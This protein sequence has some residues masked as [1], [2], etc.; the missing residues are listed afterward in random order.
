L[1]KLGRCLLPAQQGHITP[2]VR[3][4]ASLPVGPDRLLPATSLTSTTPEVAVVRRPVPHPDYDYSPKSVWSMIQASPARCPDRLALGIKRDGAWVTWTYKQYLEE[5]TTVAKAFIKLGLKPHHGVCIMGFNSPEWFISDIAAIVAGGLAT[6]IYTTNSPSAVEYVARHCRANILVVADQEQLAKVLEVREGLPELTA[7]VQYD[8]KVTEPGVLS[9]AD[10][11]QLGR[12]QAEEELQDRLRNQAVNQA[13]M[14]VYTSGT[15]GNPKGAMISQDNLTWTCEIAKQQYGWQEDQEESVTYLPLSHI[16]GNVIDIF[17]PYLAGGT[18][19]FADKD[20]LKGSLVNTLIEVRPTRFLGV[21]RVWEKIQEKL[22]EVG[23]KN[24]GLKKVVATWAKAASF[25]HHEDQMAGRPGNSWKY[26]LAKKVILTRVHA[27]LGLERAAR[28]GSLGGVYSSAAPLS[29]QTF[30]YFQ[31]LDLFVLEFLGSTETSGPMTACF[32]GTGTKQGS[33]GRGYPQFETAILAPQGEEG[34]IATRGRNCCMGYLW[35]EEKTRELIDAE[36]WLHS[37]DLGRM[38]QDGFFYI[39][40]R[41]K[42]IIITAGGENIAPVPIED[43][44]KADPGI[45]EVVS[46]AMVVGDAR[47][48]LAVILTLKSLIDENGQPLEELVPEVRVWLRKMGST[49]CT[50]REIMQEDGPGIHP[51]VQAAITE[52]LHRVNA[53]SVSKA[54]RIHKFLLLPVDFS[55]G[56]G[57]LTPTMKMRRHAIVKKYAKEVEDMYTSQYNNDGL[58]TSITV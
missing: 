10:L 12:Q 46:H 35:D 44:I 4:L 57:E 47:K 11:L 27:A 30:Q 39:T 23:S 40:G 9:W 53:L 42:E 22:L 55:I 16:A 15:T 18:V 24:T 20:A 31:A 13:C 43:N 38:D 5:I 25:E 14:V 3:F 1:L 58:Y 54:T 21:P 29:V 8:G 6:G 7:I 28:G 45:G 37:G 56:G 17:I 34:E 2:H 50:T 49:A 32:P 19:W 33:V 48:H 26:R 51:M 36:G 52:A 41:M